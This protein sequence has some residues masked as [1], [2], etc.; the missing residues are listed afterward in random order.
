MLSSPVETS[1]KM[2]TC[3]SCGKKGPVGIACC[4]GCGSE[5]LSESVSSGKGTVY[6]YTVMDFVPA[7][8]HKDK[9]PY[10]LAVVET[11]EGLRVSAIVESSEPYQVRIGT[12]VVFKE[13]TPGTGFVFSQSGT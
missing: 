2:L 4:S 1:L 3:N 11:S 8:P 12:P 13:F 5:D 7:G 6:T 10:V 9:A